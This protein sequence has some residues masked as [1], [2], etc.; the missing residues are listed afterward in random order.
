MRIYISG[1]MTGCPD[2]NRPAFDAAEKRLAARGHSAINPHRIGEPFGTAED[3][4]AS[5]A[6]YY[7]M[8]DLDDDFLN[9]TP[10]TQTLERTRIARAIMDAELAAVRSCDAIYLLRGWESSR[11]AKRELAEALQ[12]NLKIMQEGAENLTRPVR[13]DS[14][15]RQPKPKGTDK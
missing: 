7:R 4:A 12:Y 2:H 5:F 11:G 15:P 9:H 3:Q 8:L 14:S 6:E 13:G 10:S 1:R